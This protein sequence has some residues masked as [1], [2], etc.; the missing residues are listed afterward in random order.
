MVVSMYTVALNNVSGASE[1]FS[2]K[3]GPFFS[4]LV[5]SRKHIYIH[6]MQYRQ[7]SNRGRQQTESS[8]PR[9]RALKTLPRCFFKKVKG[10]NI[11]QANGRCDKDWS[12]EPG[13]M[14]R[15]WH[16]MVVMSQTDMSC[17]WLFRRE[18]SGGTG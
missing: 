14:N 9:S 6:V 7:C 17:D 10:S 2:N 11:V 4:F 1:Q 3:R 8:D 13:F 12:E 16:V 5:H 18:N 15:K